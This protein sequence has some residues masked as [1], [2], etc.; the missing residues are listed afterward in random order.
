[1]AGPTQPPSTPSRTGVP[2]HT[3]PRA[4]RKSLF[5]PMPL[6]RA[7]H[8]FQGASIKPG[9]RIQQAC[10]STTV[11]TGT[12]QSKRVARPGEKDVA[13]AQRYTGTL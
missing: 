1:M 11:L 12:L 9:R 7:G 3:G 2:P 8:R 13:S 5:P 6:G 10:T 4:G